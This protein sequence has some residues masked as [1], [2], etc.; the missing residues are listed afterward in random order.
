[1][2]DEETRRR[3]EARTQVFLED[4]CCSVGL[5]TGDDSPFEAGKET[6]FV[7]AAILDRRYMPVQFPWLV[8]LDLPRAGTET[9]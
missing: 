3:K 7:N 6:L 2:D 4:G 1:V 8:E 5:G 9:E